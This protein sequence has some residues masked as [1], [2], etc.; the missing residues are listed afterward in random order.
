MIV[1]TIMACA[2]DLPPGWE[3]AERVASLSQTPCE[4]DPYGEHDERVEV[5]FSGAPVQV[6]YKEAHFRC[7]Q[8]VEA[9]A[10]IEGAALDLLVQPIDMDP[11]VVAGCDCLYDIAMSVAEYPGVPDR[12]S[13]YR[14]WDDWNEPNPAVLIGRVDR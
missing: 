1:A 13:L 4:G 9:F 8:D 6:D 7:A 12:V 3:D 11:K 14:R 10:R 5:D 2:P